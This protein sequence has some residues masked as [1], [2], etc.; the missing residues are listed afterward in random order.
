MILNTGEVD[1]LLLTKNCFRCGREFPAASSQRV[2]DGCRKPELAGHRP[3]GQR[4]SPR[5][6]QVID[7]IRQAKLGNRSR[8]APFGGNN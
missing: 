5:E 4:L 7:L 3:I 1:F 8:I 6:R 2:C